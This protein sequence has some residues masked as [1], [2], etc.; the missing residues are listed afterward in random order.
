[1]SRLGPKR[2]LGDVGATD[3]PG[4]Q[5]M[6]ISPS[7]PSVTPPAWTDGEPVPHTVW[8]AAQVSA[9]HQRAGRYLPGCAAHPGK[10]LPALARRIIEAYSAPGDLIV[11]P[12]AGTGTTAVEA[13][14]AGRRC[15]GVELE[16]RWAAL[17]RAN[18]DHVL[19]PEARDLAEVR[20]GDARA[21][22]QLLGDLAGG[23][24]LIVTSPPYACDAGVIDKPAW[25]AGRCLCDRE[26]LNYS[27]SRNN[28]G[29][30]RGET[31]LAEMAAV[32]A[33][34]H[35]VLRPGGLMVTVTK[36]MRRAGRLVDLAGTTVRLAHQ[37]G[38]S[39]L[40]HNI[41]LLGALRDGEIVAH[42]SFWQ[43]RHARLARAAGQPV[44]LTVHEDVLV[45]AARRTDPRRT[46]PDRP[47]HQPA[48]A[49]S[50]HA[51]DPGAGRG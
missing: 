22:P 9:Q 49:A 32:Y 50:R 39:Y 47:R 31:Y 41:A 42:P 17:A 14:L 15:V 2:G 34:C 30:A 35:A 40:Q 10:M 6:P 21:L 28:L 8:P 1:M 16:D 51:D 12:M 18:L 5:P 26:S 29:H 11:D 45:F 43:L 44:H 46:D 27:A 19:A 25:Q 48:V 7:S 38:F 33:A 23:V 3:D 13:A 20:A 24:D 4:A 37:A 36:N